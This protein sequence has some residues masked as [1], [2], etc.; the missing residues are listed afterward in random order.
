MRNK[1]I[2]IMKKHCDKVTVC[3]NE[4]HVHTARQGC[5]DGPKDSIDILYLC[6]YIEILEKKLLSI[7]RL[8]K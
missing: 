5:L 3:C 8:T 2:K 6:E 7:N 1:V 4:N